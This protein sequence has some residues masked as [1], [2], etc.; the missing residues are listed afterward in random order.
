MLVTLDIGRVE[1]VLGDVHVRTS[2]GLSDP[3]SLIL[4]DRSKGY[5]PKT[6]YEERII[7]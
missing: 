1:R 7:M 3:N 5:L 4:I 2:S 6:D